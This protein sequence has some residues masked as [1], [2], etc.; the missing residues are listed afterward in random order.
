M[1]QEAHRAGLV[2]LVLCLQACG[3]GAPPPAAGGESESAPRDVRVATLAS[4]PS[5]RLLFATGEILPDERVTVSTKV[6]GRLAAIQAERGLAVRQGEVLARLEA[7]EYELR[8]AQA[9]AAL[10]AAR[11]QLGLAEGAGDEVASEDTA[12]VRLARAGLER[13]GFERERARALAREGVDSQ[14]ALDRAETDL[15][16]AESRL[17]EALELV[18]TRRATLA[19]RRAELEIARA[20]LAET[21]LE[22]PFDGVVLE[23]LVSP[24]TYL[25]IGAGVCELVRID[26]L[27]LVLELPA[28]DA[29]R[30]ALGTEVRATLV[31]EAAPLVGSVTRLAPALS[32]ASRTRA[33]EVALANPAQRALAGAFAEVHLVIARDQPALLVPLGALRSFAGLDKLLLVKDGVLEERR[34]TCGAPRDGRVE[35]LSGAAAGDVYALEPGTLASGARVRVVP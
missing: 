18:S 10:A 5:E 26:P 2:L 22:A 15:R 4:E 27:R 34:V 29:A 35:V 28:A 16:A 21:T 19:Q 6:P 30:V 7:R 17:Q 25:A 13:A 24:G 31:G 23:R 1:Q 20:Q 8:V 14:A 11:A 3:P 32:S 33:V 9:E 12:V